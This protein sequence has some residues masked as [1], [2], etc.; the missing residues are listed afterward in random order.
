MT[1]D[2][3]EDRLTAVVAE[4]AEQ[5][6]IKQIYDD[7]FSPSVREGGSALTD[8]IKTLRLA[9]APIQFAAAV[10]DRYRDFLDRSVRR[11]PKED[12]VP[13]P[14]QILGPVLEGIRYEPE[15]TPIEEMFSEL[16]S[17]SD[18]RAAS[19]RSSSLLR[20]PH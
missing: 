19:Q 6:P 20:I 16:L 17:R 3:A 1:S 18:G 12:R 2:S 15:G 8:L 9:F 4:I 13:P 5:L 11:V 10:Q 7:G 14:P